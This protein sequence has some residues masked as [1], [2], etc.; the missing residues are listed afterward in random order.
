MRISSGFGIK[1][2]TK[3]KPK[4]GSKKDKGKGLCYKCGQMGHYKPDCPNLKRNIKG[5][6]FKGRRKG[7]RL[8]KHVKVQVN[9]PP[10]K[11]LVRKN[12]K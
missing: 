3:V 8:T 2:T 4:D 12:K 5:K 9:H 1:P 10:K 7:E 11:A 6:T